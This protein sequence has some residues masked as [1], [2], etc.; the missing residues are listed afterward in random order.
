M[1][2]VEMNGRPFT[3]KKEIIRL[4][5]R[6][7]LPHRK[8]TGALF[9]FSGLDGT[10][11]FDNQLVGSVMEEDYGF[12]LN[13]TSPAHMS[14][15]CDNQYSH[16]FEVTR[17]LIVSDAVSY[18]VSKPDT[19]QPGEIRFIM[20]DD[21]TV[22]GQT[23]ADF[24][25]FCCNGDGFQTAEPS[26]DGKTVLSNNGATAV[27][28]TRESPAGIAFAFSMSLTGQAEAEDRA[29]KALELDIEAEF[30]R[31]KKF[32]DA[33][34]APQTDDPLL[35][36]TYCKAMSVMKSMVY[37]PAGKAK[38]RWTTPDRMP[39]KMM[40]LWDSAFHAIG[41]QHISPQLAREAIEAVFAYQEED[42]FIPHM[43]ATGEC[44]QV[45]QPP[46]LGWAAMEIFKKNGGN[47]GR[48]FLGRIA[49]P[50]EKFIRWVL[51][52][53]AKRDGDSLG[54]SIRKRYSFPLCR[55]GET[56]MD[57]SPRFDCTDDAESVDIISFVIQEIDMLEKMCE[58][59]G[60]AMPA[61]LLEKRQALIDTLQTLFW[62]ED[63]KFFYDRQHNGDFIR[64][65]TAAAF[66]PL[67]AGAATDAQAAAMI[68]HLQNPREFWTHFPVPS[69][70]V[71]EPAY[72]KDYWRGPTWVNYNYL[73]M[74]GLK[75]YGFAE[76][77][78]KLRR[79]TINEIARWYQSEGVLFELYDAEG[80]VSPEHL[81]HRA[82]ILLSRPRCLVS[83]A[84][85]D[86]GWTAALFAHL[87]LDNG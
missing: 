87:V 6:K 11:D 59:L 79:R 13:I 66:T 70:A 17:R 45:I 34:P 31:K 86:F 8:A 56:G 62:D 9:A 52:H 38:T 36:E 76:L 60:R 16:P 71:S 14:L 78:E 77:A 82:R 54:W 27:L 53:R 65:K 49:G 25:V 47:E 20:V 85:K 75:R 40:W 23:T 73:V 74:Q 24:P 64:V 29:R 4:M 58:P 42:G 72:T 80:E 15:W 3:E 83:G 1:V 43:M 33:L 10:V 37:S 57:N 18:T 28:L 30:E 55:S 46:I 51:E 35:A 68:E 21:R 26:E 61:D 32:F 84:V 2:L 19:T 7:V 5:D 39:H 67:F 69:T 48:E 81:K 41:M 50:L 63:E 12:G 44:S 22:L